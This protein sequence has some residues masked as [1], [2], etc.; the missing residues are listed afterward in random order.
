MDKFTFVALFHTRNTNWARR[1]FVYICSAPAPPPP[2]PY[3]VGQV[4]TLF[5]QRFNIVWG[6]GGGSN[7]FW[8][9]K[10]CFFKTPF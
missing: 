6:E 7:A 3:N 2:F 5:L 9:G 8:N 4:Y 1:E 10:Q